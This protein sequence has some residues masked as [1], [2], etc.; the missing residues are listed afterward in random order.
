MLFYVIRRVGGLF[1]L[2]AESE[3]LCRDCFRLTTTV[4]TTIAIYSDVVRSIPVYK[5]IFL[6]ISTSAFQ[7]ATPCIVAWYIISNYA[8]FA[9]NLKNIGL[10]RKNVAIIA[11]LSI[12]SVL[13][14]ILFSFRYKYP[15]SCS[16]LLQVN[17]F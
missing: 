7:I 10:Y 16:R 3:C 9:E 14:F 15:D 1:E 4:A 5:M 12:I 11:V 17:L 13:F 2:L 8:V 6:Q